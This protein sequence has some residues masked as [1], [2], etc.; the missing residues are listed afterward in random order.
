MRLVRVCGRSFDAV[1]AALCC[2]GDVIVAASLDRSQVGAVL[3]IE[4]ASLLTPTFFR[5]AWS[6]IRRD[7]SGGWRVNHSI[8]KSAESHSPS[9]K[10]Q[11]VSPIAE[12]R[13]SS[14]TPRSHGALG[15]VSRVSIGADG[16]FLGEPDRTAA[17]TDNVKQWLLRRR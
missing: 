6:T 8:R 14:E 17:D 13:S 1:P 9:L 7:S 10:S 3:F 2:D 12:A 15:L 4:S 11:N 16:P 5:S